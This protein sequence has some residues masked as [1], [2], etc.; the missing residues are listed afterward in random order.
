M[1]AML[2]LMG[3]AGTALLLQPRAPLPSE[4]DF[5]IA[6][7]KLTR[8]PDDPDA[9]GVVGKY[10]SFVQ[11]N[12]QDGM[13]YLAK[14]SDKLKTLASHDS[15]PAY[16]DSGPKKV[17]MGDEWVIAAKTNPALFRIFYD[18]ASQWYATAFPDL[19]GPWKD[20]AR[21]QGLKLASSRPSGG[22]RR[23]LPAGW[24][25]ET[26]I[27]GAKSPVLDGQIAHVGSYSVRMVPA[28][29]KVPGSWSGLKTDL[30]PVSGKVLEISAYVRSD[31][32][33]NASD[34]VFVNV[35]DRNG[36]GI[37]TIGPYVPMDLPFWSRVYTKVDLNPNIAKIQF[38][39]SLYSKKGTFWVDDAS[40]KIDGKEIL[41][42]GSF[43]ER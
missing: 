41:K 25:A 40:V 22:P 35:F 39:A 16:T 4:T 10:V 11:G 1:D 34:R 15:D 28:D 38:G 2:A 42:N 29:E 24:Q 19:D 7:D 30:I 17:G 21:E 13:K 14:S 27:G 5:R 12:Y 31:G 36:T 32:T 3:V 8:N 26:A 37:G 6:Q 9:N 43:E 23:G 18:R 20:K 33:D